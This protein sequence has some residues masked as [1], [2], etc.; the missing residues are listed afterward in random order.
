MSDAQ[1]RRTLRDRVFQ[2]GVGW[3]QSVLGAAGVTKV[4]D[5]TRPVGC[6]D[7]R[8][9]LIVR[10]GVSTYPDAGLAPS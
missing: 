6:G 1:L 7:R 4:S 10:N 2:R 8:A 3:P 9:R 5:L